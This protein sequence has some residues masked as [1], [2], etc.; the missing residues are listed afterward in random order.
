MS[1]VK[2]STWNLIGTAAS[3]A[4][5]I[6]AMGFFA[7][8]LDT[9][10]FGLLTLVLAFVGYASVLDGGFARAV[11]REIA[12]AGDDTVNAERALGTG[13]VVVCV[14]G[15]IFGCLLWL[16][17]P[18]L[19]ELIN[20]DASLQ[21]EAVSGFR[22]TAFM[23]LPIL[24]GM[25]WM[26]PMEARADFALLNLMRSVGYALVF[27]GAVFAVFLLPTFSVAVV[28]L[29]A[30]RIAMA[31]VG[32]VATRQVMG[33]YFFPFCSDALKRLV[34]FGG[35]LTVSS[36]VSPL[37]YYLDRFVLSAFAG[38]SVVAFYAAPSEAVG[39][40]QSLPGSVARAIFPMLASANPDEAEKIRRHAMMIQAALGLSLVMIVLLFGNQIVEMWLGESYVAK[41]SLIMKIMVFGVLFNAMGMI[42]LIELQAMG[43]SKITAKAHLIEVVPVIALL[44]VMTAQF[45]IT[46]TAVA[47][48]S[49]TLFDWCLQSYLCQKAKRLRLAEADLVVIQHAA[50]PGS[51]HNV[52]PVIIIVNWNSWE[53][54][55][56]CINACGH[57]VGFDGAVIVV[58]NGSTDDS[59]KQLQAW[60]QG[61]VNIQTTSR[62]AEIAALEQPA[63]QPLLFMGIGDE[64]KL[65]REIE[66]NGLGQ[67][68]WYLVDAGKNEGFGAGNNI[69]LRLAM[70]DR[71]CSLFWCLNADAIPQ[72]SAWVELASGCGQIVSPCV[73]GAVLLN[74]D[75]PDTIQTVGS[76][77]SKT[78]LVASFLHGNEPISILDDL[79]EK[80]SVGYPSGASLVLNRAY[81][82]KFGYFDETYF[83]YYEEPDLVVRLK[84]ATQSFVCT[85]SRVYH[86]GGQTTGGGGCVKDRSPLADYEYNRSRMILAKKLG[87]WIVPLMVL[88]V[89]LSILRRIRYG[90]LDLAR[91]V[92]LACVDGWR[93]A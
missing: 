38:A 30:G 83:L 65:S 82:E 61:L 84:D 36:I 6:P 22:W 64:L 29:L 15:V 78:T 73:A 54:T 48:V 18:S 28:G 74:Y 80:L 23:I 90:R 44:F 58:D 34:K 77:F 59:L 35:W 86:K 14:L 69:G 16:G 79:P 71:A 88:A 43:L 4:V 60:S 12:Q 45:G 7:R 93:S 91:R 67:R 56:R 27:G 21:A 13:V 10:S 33:Q 26:A 42:P 63:S 75:Q 47:W 53:D 5:M 11:V 1:V 66:I 31:L 85:R 40:M 32:L 37:M 25:V 55:A 92:I 72:R 70:K 76:A 17:A 68:G 50:T 89:T 20:V 81:I 39:K 41:S 19:V 46:G 57:L 8:Q 62:T 24:L 2:N 49:A 3:A 52:M 9:E 51:I 87:G